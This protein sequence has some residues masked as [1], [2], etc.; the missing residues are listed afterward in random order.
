MPVTAFG[1]SVQSSCALVELSASL[2]LALLVYVI[3]S[4]RD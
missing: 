1:D 4:A 2:T 3:K